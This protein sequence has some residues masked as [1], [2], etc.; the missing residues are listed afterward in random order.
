[1]NRCRKSISQVGDPGGMATTGEGET[2]GLCVP[3]KHN[4]QRHFRTGVA[5]VVALALSTL[6][7]CGVQP[8][9][10]APGT[11]VATV[12]PA[13]S[14][15]PTTPAVP[16]ASAPTPA[17]APTAATTAQVTFTAKALA[18]YKLG[19]DETKVVAKLTQLLGKPTSHHKGSSC[20]IFDDAPYASWYRFGPLDVSFM[21]KNAKSSSPRT[22]DSFGLPLSSATDP[23]FAIAADL[24]ITATF[25]KLK[26]LY[27]KGTAYPGPGSPPAER[28][29]ELPGGDVTFSGDAASDVPDYIQ[30]GPVG[31]C[32]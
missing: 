14:P 22:M 30:I 16:S 21:A 26:T 12:A 25:T 32:E 20:E 2:S 10:A 3:D 15:A 17:P 24:P 27:P 1:M 18:G 29:F 23:R 11:P 6:G 13:T 4:R 7:G 28:F 8:P 5:A 19:S 31:F 9:V